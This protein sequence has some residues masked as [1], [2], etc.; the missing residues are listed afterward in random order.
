MLLL[1]LWIG[2]FG[3]VLTI[4]LSLG[5]PLSNYPG[6]I[7]EWI[8]DYGVWGGIVYV[9]IYLIRPLLFV[10]ATLLT[11]V[12]GLAFGPWWGI[13]YT[14]IGENI[15]ANLT[16]VIGRFFGK[17]MVE[18][19]TAKIMYIN[20]IDCAFRNNGFMSVFVMRLTHLPFDLVGYLSGAC[21]LRHRDFAL[22]TFIGILPG[23]VTFVLLGASFTDPRNLLLVI[24]SLVT[25]LLVS[26]WL[27]VHGDRVH[28]DAVQSR[29]NPVSGIKPDS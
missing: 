22:G 3:V 19:L 5:I 9:L 16:F 4:Y 21:N 11:T 12:S 27:K 25:G 6:L 2:L 15:S 8:Q 17:T 23:L 10:P 24:V 13:I 20:R 29:D 18:R 1:I 7:Q 14:I 28:V 26:K